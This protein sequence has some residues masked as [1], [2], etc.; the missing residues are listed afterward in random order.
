MHR[1]PSIRIF[2]FLLLLQKATL[3]FCSN[4]EQSVLTSGL[5]SDSLSEEALWETDFDQIVTSIGRGDEYVYYSRSLNKITAD[6]S[7][8]EVQVSINV[9]NNTASACDEHGRTIDSWLRKAALADRIEDLSISS[10]IRKGIVRPLYN[11]LSLNFKNICRSQLDDF[12]VKYKDYD[13]YPYSIFEKRDKNLYEQLYPPQTSPPALTIVAGSRGLECQID[14]KPGI[15]R[16]TDFA[17][18]AAIQPKLNQ[19]LP[20]SKLNPKYN[21]LPVVDATN[22]QDMDKSYEPYRQ[23]KPGLML[24]VR[25]NGKGEILLCRLLRGNETGEDVLKEL[26]VFDSIRTSDPSIINV[27]KIRGLVRSPSG[28][29]LGILFEYFEV[30]RHLDGRLIG[31]TWADRMKLLGQLQDGVQFVATQSGITHEEALRSR[32][33]IDTSGRLWLYNF[34]AGDERKF[35]LK[36]ASEYLES[37]YTD[38]DEKSRYAGWDE[39]GWLGSVIRALQRDVEIGEKAA[40]EVNP[41][42]GGAVFLDLDDEKPK[43]DD[44]T[45]S[46]L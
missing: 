23:A 11:E 39:M 29:L 17:T 5:E 34:F 7:V 24:E 8:N 36:W 1:N 9:R 4:D 10:K 21:H 44:D 2:S 30:S 19:L 26:D 28:E 27:P 15:K 43:C 41:R 37:E 6:V 3:C 12:A 40:N 46:D 45:P 22:I 42:Y 20:V 25:V 14:D 35:K 13:P 16:F 33:L 18:H 32:A 31:G 38:S